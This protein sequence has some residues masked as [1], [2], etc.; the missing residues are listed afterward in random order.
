[1]RSA[2]P[3]DDCGF[4]FWNNPL[5]V[6]A[7]LVELEGHILL[8]RNKAWPEKFFGLITGFVE[9]GESPE[10][11]VAREVKEELGLDTEAASLIG[12]YPFPVKNEIIMAFYISAKGTLKTSDEIA[13][14]SSVP[15][16]K[17]KPWS[18]GTGLAVRDWLNTRNSKTAG[19]EQS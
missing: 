11:A 1:M 12:L 19:K 14:V 7:A 6:V 16:E 3:S 10:E 17:L 18:F 13:E 2:C 5:P 8:A 9:K 15:P 4:V